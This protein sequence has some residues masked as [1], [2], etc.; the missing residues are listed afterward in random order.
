MSGVRSA[1]EKSSLFVIAAGTVC[2]LGG[3][4]VRAMIGFALLQFGTLEFKSNIHPTIER[5]IFSL[6]AQSSLIVNISYVLVV[7]AAVA[8]LR[9]TRLRVKQEGWLM[10]SAILFFVFVP[11]EIYTMVLDVRMWLLDMSGS[12]DLVEFR[13]LFIHRLAALSGVPM[14]ALLSY[15]TIIGLAI[16]RPLRRGEEHP[17]NP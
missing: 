16:I 11:V 13:K 3:I 9:S 7:I 8:Y 12:N 5:T 14:I 4:N 15:Y 10:I 6:V 2:W 17:V 1:V